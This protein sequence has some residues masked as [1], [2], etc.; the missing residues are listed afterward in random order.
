[1]DKP[2]SL[3]QRR[4]MCYRKDQ[5]LLPEMPAAM[6]KAATDRMGGD[7]PVMDSNAFEDSYE[8]LRTMLSVERPMQLV[9]LASA[10]AFVLCIPQL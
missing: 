9:F 8:A 1:M 5:L 4:L 10:A 3:A 7:N 2:I 6:N